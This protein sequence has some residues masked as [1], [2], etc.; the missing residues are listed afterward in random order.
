MPCLAPL[1][2]RC[3]FAPAGATAYRTSA[4]LQYRN[5][6]QRLLPFRYGRTAFRAGRAVRSYRVGARKS[7]RF[8]TPRRLSGGR[9]VAVRPP[10]R[11]GMTIQ[12]ELLGRVLVRAL[13]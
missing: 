2:G 1:A 11:V 12:N 10:D 7:A 6:T 13:G 8:A 3:G 5:G 4:D 9:T